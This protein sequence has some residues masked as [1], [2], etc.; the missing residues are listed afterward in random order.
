V[1]AVGFF[2]VGAAKPLMIERTPGL[3]LDG[4][5]EESDGGIEIE[6][7]VGAASEPEV[8]LGI[9]GG[10]FERSLKRLPGGNVVA[11]IET[12]FGGAKVSSVIGRGRRD[13]VRAGEGWG[14]KRGRAE[15]GSEK[16]SDSATS[17]GGLTR[18]PKWHALSSVKVQQRP[19]P[20]MRRWLVLVRSPFTVHPLRGDHAPRG[21]GLSAACSHFK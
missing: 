4:A 19:V 18:Q 3:E 20:W 17:D 11:G 16:E 8:N 21:D 12:F 9:I 7:F 10:F 1:L 5:L 13:A 15:E 2:T 14:E 6:E